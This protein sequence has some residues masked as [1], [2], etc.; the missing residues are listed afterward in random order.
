VKEKLEKAFLDVFRRH[1][2]KSI[3]ELDENNPLIRNERQMKLGP[4]YSPT[5]DVAVGPFSFKEGN[6]NDVYCNL[7]RIGEIERFVRGLQEIGLG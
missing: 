5:C 3:L 4:L 1:I 2:D 7:M 6:L